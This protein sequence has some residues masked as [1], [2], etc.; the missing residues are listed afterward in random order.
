M[1]SRFCLSVVII[2][3]FKQ[4]TSQGLGTTHLHVVFTALTVSHIRYALPAE[5]GLSSELLN[6]L[7]FS[8][9]KHYKF[10][11]TT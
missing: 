5:V 6:K 11:Y 7:M 3:L 2:C 8:Y 9:V 10:V 4:L 1:S